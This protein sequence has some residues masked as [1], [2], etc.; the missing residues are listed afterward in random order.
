MAD[1]AYND[2]SQPEHKQAVPRVQALLARNL[3]R[4]DANGAEEDTMKITRAL[5]AAR[6]EHVKASSLARLVCALV[7]VATAVLAAHLLARLSLTDSLGIGTGL[8]VLW[9]AAEAHDMRRQMVRQ[10]EIAIQPVVVADVDSGFVLKNLGRGPA[11]FVRVVDLQ[12]TDV[13][14]DNVPFTAKFEPINV[15]APGE[16]VM[17]TIHCTPVRDDLTGTYFDALPSLRRETAVETYGVVIQYEDVSGLRRLT[18][19]QM[20]KDGTRLLWHGRPKRAARAWL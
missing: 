17:P 4:T 16:Q 6:L 3:P 2:L 11:L 15:V 5:F 1:P 12:L 8:L 20:G 19:V 10:N 9:Y 13:A 14:G 7:L 18:A